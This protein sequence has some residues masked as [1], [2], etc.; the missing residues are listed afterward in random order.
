MSRLNIAVIAG[1][2]VGPEM[3]E[4]AIKVLE[5]VSCL[6]SHELELSVVPACGQ[7]I[8]S[9]GDP[10]PE[11]SLNRCRQAKAVLFG[12]SGLE[13]YKDYPLEKRPEYALLK[14]RRELGVTANIRPVH[15]YPELAA[16]S[17]LK[18]RQLE[19]GVDIV[20][21]RD[22]VGGVLCSQKYRSKG[23]GGLEAYEREYYNEK[24]VLDTARI[25]FR[26]AKQR[27]G[28][29]V[30]LDKANVLESSRLWRDMMAR[31]AADFPQVRLEHC[32]IDTAAMRL[33]DCPWEF[34]TVAASNLFGDIIADE[35]TQLT[36]TPRLFA[37]AEISAA[38]PAVYTPNQLHEADESLV[39]RDQVNPIGMI[40]AAGLMLD[41]TFGLRTEA[42]VL[43]KAIK[44]VIAAGYST[45]DLM[46]PGRILTGTRQMGQLVAE[47]LKEEWGR[48][49]ESGV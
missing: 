20:F 22:I 28:K 43:T 37:S 17:P 2:G 9:C 26:L 35:G 10:L 12:N 45:G 33:L 18:E 21:V 40:Q 19:R 7:T 34:D 3:M 11:T 44:Q 42:E 31:T 48:R 49:K 24:I 1:D 36:G 30:S 6:G 29:L 13:K 38:G 4:P 16:L 25:A 23:A 5:T 47:A 32:F 39:G 27:G 41:M 14:L 15:I 46:C 8:D